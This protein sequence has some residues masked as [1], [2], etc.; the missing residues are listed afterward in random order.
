MQLMI[1]GRSKQV[2]TIRES[3][4]KILTL[5][6]N[7]AMTPVEDG[8]S[9]YVADDGYTITQI[10]K[11]SHIVLHTQGDWINFDLFS[12]K[13]F[14]VSEVVRFFQEAFNIVEIRNIQILQR[15]FGIGKET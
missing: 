13:W 11:E 1:D 8:R 6:A 12:C 10:I 2:P 15:P 5:C 4:A 14:F 9:E 3:V 7:I